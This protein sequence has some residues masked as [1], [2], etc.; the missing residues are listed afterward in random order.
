MHRL[1]PTNFKF[2]KAAVTCMCTEKYM[3]KNTEIHVQYTATTLQSSTEDDELD[4]LETSLH[5]IG[6]S[7]AG[8][9][10]IFPAQI[11][12]LLESSTM[13]LNCVGYN[14]R[15]LPWRVQRGLPLE[16]QRTRL[17]QCYSHPTPHPAKCVHTRPPRNAI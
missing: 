12:W 8:N 11:S 10:V 15:S 16:G 3:T 9:S 13:Y 1:S 5:I 2:V 7:N 17:I 6:S 14:Y 4:L